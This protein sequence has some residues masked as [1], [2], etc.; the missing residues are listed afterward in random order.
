MV[1]VSKYDD[2]KGFFIC[3]VAKMEKQ[4]LARTDLPINFIDDKEFEPVKRL[5]D[6]KINSFFRKLT[7]LSPHK[8][9][10]EKSKFE[11]NQIIYRRIITDPF[12]MNAAERIFNTENDTVVKRLIKK[13]ALDNFIRDIKK[14]FEL[15]ILVLSAFE[16]STNNFKTKI[17][18]YGRLKIGDPQEQLLFEDVWKVNKECIKKFMKFSPYNTFFTVNIE[19]KYINNK[20]IKEIKFSTSHLYNRYRQ[21]RK[22]KQKEEK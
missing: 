9:E 11:F 13:A 14:V 12:L 1:A 10:L 8:I 15:P 19:G 22:R 20:F 17:N 7:K 18:Q 4:S 5:I 21:F 16:S 6:K 2:S 3:V